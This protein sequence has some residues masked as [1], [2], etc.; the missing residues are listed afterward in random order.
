VV[1]GCDAPPSS[2]LTVGGGPFIAEVYQTPSCTSGCSYWCTCC[3]FGGASG[4]GNVS[5][6]VRVSPHSVTGPA[7][8]WSLVNEL[9]VSGGAAASSPL[10][11]CE[12]GWGSASGSGGYVCNLLF[13]THATSRLFFTSAQSVQIWQNGQGNSLVALRVQDGPDLYTRSISPAGGR[14]DAAGSI[15]LALPPGRYEL[16]MEHQAGASGE[17]P[18]GLAAGSV[19][20]T[21]VSTLNI[22]P[23]ACP[24]VTGQPHDVSVSI[25]GLAIFVVAASGDDGPSFRWRRN[26]V[27]LSDGPTPTGSYVSGVYQSI[28]RIYGVQAADAGMY[29]FVVTNRCGDVASHAARL[30]VCTADFNLS[31]TLS[32]QDIFDFLAAYFGNDPLADFNASGTISVQDIFDFLA[33]YFAGCA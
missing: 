18:V 16:R 25:G 12:T 20:C 3:R 30:M 21:L 9:S 5:S 10:D 1:G 13:E 33:A 32:V 4:R 19:L 27:P 11:E 29:D 15:D 7:V 24:E 8:A 2:F 22:A 14:E 6:Y 31:G 17:F 28:M 23:Y 26:G